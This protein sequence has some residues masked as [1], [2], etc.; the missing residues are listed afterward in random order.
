[1]FTNNIPDGTIT[2]YS[3]Y[4][5]TIEVSATAPSDVTFT[6]I[7]TPGFTNLK[8]NSAFTADTATT[9]L[10]C[11]GNADSATKDGSGNNIVNTYARINKVYDD[12]GDYRQFLGK[13]G[14]SS[15]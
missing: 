9:A 15:S 1:M 2:V 3:P 10:S 5:C 6:N 13:N 7:N 8:A 11:S 14:D 12:S 4:N